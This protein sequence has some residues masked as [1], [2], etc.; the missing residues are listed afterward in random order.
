VVADVPAEHVRLYPPAEVDLI[1]VTS[2]HPRARSVPLL[3]TTRHGNPF[4]DRTWSRE[5]IKWRDA[6]G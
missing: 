6:A 2:G 1:D 5:W 4:T 3:F